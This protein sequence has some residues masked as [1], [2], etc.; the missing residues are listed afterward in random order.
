MRISKQA[1]LALAIAAPLM[2]CVSANQLAM[3]IGA[4]PE[5]AVELRTLQMR[6]F[7]TLD[8]TRMLL[9]ATDTLQ[10]LGYTVTESSNDLGLIVGSKQR[11]AEETGQVAGQ[12][13][14]TV[15]FAAMGS[16]YNPTWDKSQSIHVTLVATPVENSKQ[17]EVRVSFD[18]A[19]TNNHGHEWRAD[20]ILDEK[21]YQEFFEKLSA[22]AFLEAESV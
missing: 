16:Y 22:S 19:L 4:P 8:Q 3:K 2:S 21:I 20:L 5:T 17:I 14:L 9:A 1:L 13:M 6:R 15:L 10:D 12:V 11:D 7:D 18:R